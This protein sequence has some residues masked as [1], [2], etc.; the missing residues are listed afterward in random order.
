MAEALCGH[1]IFKAHPTVT[2]QTARKVTATVT[3]NTPIRCW[4]PWLL[5]PYAQG[6]P[7]PSLGTRS[8]L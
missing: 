6:Y 2:E 8:S 5:H 4:Q 3:A 1:E 7:N